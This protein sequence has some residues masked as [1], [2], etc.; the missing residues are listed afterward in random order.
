MTIPPPP[1]ARRKRP[2]YAQWWAIVL[3]AVIGV[4]MLGGIVGAMSGGDDGDSDDTANGLDGAVDDMNDAA[5][6]FA[7][8]AD[9]LGPVEF[10]E[11]FE[12][13]TET[14]S[15]DATITLPEEADQGIIT[16]SHSGSGVFSIEVIDENNESTGDFLAFT[17]GAYD[18]TTAF[19]LYDFS[20][21]GPPDSLKI[22]AD[23]D[24]EITI[25]P[26]SEAPVLELPAE[27]DGDAVYRF[28][29][30]AADWTL[31]HDGEGVFAVT[32]FNNTDL[33]SGLPLVMEMGA[34]EG[35]VPVTGDAG[36]VT[37]TADGS[38]TI[39]AS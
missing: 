22:A 32:R 30:D 16:A 26:L 1:P 13:V 5:E 21:A 33:F 27:G 28:E 12:A 35:T 20:I 11:S 29:G 18:G 10:G 31:T 3:Y 6:S 23:G 37:I 39:T 15:G 14:G 4:C 34:Y 2:W 19:G 36:I 24:W 8:A 17:M 9:E 38:W 25:A 7:D